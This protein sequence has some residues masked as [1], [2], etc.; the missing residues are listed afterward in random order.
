M[1]NASLT[2]ISVPHAIGIGL[3]QILSL[4]PGVSRM[5]LTTVTGIGL[6]ITPLVSFLY[7]LTCELA[8]IFVAAIVTLRKKNASPYLYFSPSQTSI[9]VMSCLFSLFALELSRVS[10]EHGYASLLGGYLIL[11]AVSLAALQSIDNKNRYK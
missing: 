2:T 9:L 11:L 5:A 3:A 10:F 1:G 6:G 8:L 4:A 7:S